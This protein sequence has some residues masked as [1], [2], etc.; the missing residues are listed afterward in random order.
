MLVAIPIRYDFLDNEQ[1]AYC[2]KR[3]ITFLQ[4]YGISSFIVSDYSQLDKIVNICDMLL[5]PGGYDM[6]PSFLNQQV[7]PTYP[8]YN[9]EVDILDILLIK[10]FHDAKKPILGICR[11]M[12]LINI[13]FHGTLFM[14]I[15][16]HMKQNHALYFSKQSILKPYYPTQYESNSYHHQAIDVLGEGLCIDAITKDGIIEAISYEDYIIGLQWHPELLDHDP[17]LLYFLLY[18]EKTSLQNK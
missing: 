17:I 12:Q 15:K 18:L 14:D 7:D 9:Q 10:G 13:Y 3:Y 11:G 8:Y 2:N 5:I 1:K 16:H 4:K 6:H